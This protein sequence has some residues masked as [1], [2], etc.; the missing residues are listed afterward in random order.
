MTKTLKEIVSFLA[1]W[2]DPFAEVEDSRDLRDAV[3]TLF[4]DLKLLPD[5]YFRVSGSYSLP[6]YNQER[7]ELFYVPDMVKLRHLLGK[8]EYASFLHE[9]YD[10]LW[11]KIMK[12]GEEAQ[13]DHL[14]ANIKNAMIMVISDGFDDL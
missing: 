11:Y 1:V 2:N 6:G 13:A 5:E 10:F 3:R 14:P 12:A 7:Y 4:K 9:A 8:H